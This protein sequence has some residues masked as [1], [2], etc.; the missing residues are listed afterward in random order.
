[1]IDERDDE[2]RLAQAARLLGA[3][4]AERLDVEGTAAAVLERLRHEGVRPG[5]RW[6]WVR[7]AWWRVAAAI[8][9]LAGAGLV[10]RSQFFPHETAPLSRYLSADLQGLTS[11]Q[12]QEVL[13][14]L[15]QTLSDSTPLVPAED[16]WNDMTTEQLQAVL[17]SLEG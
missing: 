9:L 11:D 2:A 1:M 10:A 13:S 17:R 4:A 3:A 5:S 8:V 14:T 15:D 6:R 12:L 7:P 16:D